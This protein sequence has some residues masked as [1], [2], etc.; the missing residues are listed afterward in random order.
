MM[1][2]Y[3]YV[4]PGY[5]RNGFMA[6]GALGHTRQVELV[7]IPSK[8]RKKFSDCHMFITPRGNHQKYPYP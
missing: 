3:I 1:L 8:P 6:N 7:K 2:Y 4:P 5:H